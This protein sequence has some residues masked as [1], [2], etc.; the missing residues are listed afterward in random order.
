MS[1]IRGK[2]TKPE[3]VLRSALHRLGVRFR[4][5]VPELRGRPDIVFPKYRAVVMVNGCF[6]H[7]HGCRYFRWPS[8]NVEFWREK[9]EATRRRDSRDLAEL[10][11]LGWRV[12][13]V[14]ECALRGRHV[15]AAAVAGRVSAWLRT[16]APTDEIAESP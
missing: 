8:T 6:F 15:D 11:E 16:G 14:W 2:D 13:V 12:M 9:I 7:G 4:V 3:V 1:A 5:H 10:R